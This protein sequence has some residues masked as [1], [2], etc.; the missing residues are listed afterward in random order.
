MIELFSPAFTF[1][2][3]DSLSDVQLPSACLVKVTVIGVALPDSVS[4]V[5]VTSTISPVFALLGT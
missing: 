2:T 3:D 4:G 5:I 1:G